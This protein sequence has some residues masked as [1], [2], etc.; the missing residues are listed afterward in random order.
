LQGELFELRGTAERSRHL[1]DSLCQLVGADGGGIGYSVD[2]RPG[3]QG[4]LVQVH[5]S[6]FAAAD[7]RR[8]VIDELQ[9]S[10]ALDPAIG[11]LMR[12]PRTATVTRRR[13]E[14]VTEQHWYRSAYVNEISRVAGIDDSM[15]S[16]MP[17]PERD[18]VFGFGLYRQWG[19]R[20]F[21]SGEREL[22]DLFQQEAAPIYR[23]I[24]LA[25][26]PAPSVALSPRLEETLRGLLAGLAE[27]EI[28]A[29]IG[30]S[31]HTVHDYVKELYARFH[32]ASRAQLLAALLG[33]R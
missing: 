8:M 18:S 12:Y 13:C 33:S 32:V 26:D 16:I 24:F 6:G 29:H 23:S 27:K 7:E 19:R 25:A 4:R 10:T 3:G 28:A 22:L 11:R 30:I 21:S 2:F 9:P 14:L 5:S 1:I 20:P 15:Y 17:G 31:Q